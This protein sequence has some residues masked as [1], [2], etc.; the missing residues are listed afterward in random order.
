MVVEG[1]FLPETVD[2][3]PDFLVNGAG[4]VKFFGQF[5]QDLPQ[6]LGSQS[7]GGGL[8]E[9]QDRAAGGVEG[10]VVGV[11]GAGLG[12]PSCRLLPVPDLFRE[13]FLELF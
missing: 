5:F 9:S 1:P 6:P 7:A 2:V 4:G 12:L 11:G 10:P 3:V 13:L 8:V